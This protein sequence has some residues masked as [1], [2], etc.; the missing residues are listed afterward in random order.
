MTAKLTRIP[1][2]GVEIMEA[3]Q[4]LAG[5]GVLVGA[6]DRPYQDPDGNDPGMMVSEILEI[7]E[8]GLG[9]PQ[10]SVIRATLASRKGE[11]AA[12]A[13]EAA[14]AVTD[15]ADPGAE[16]EGVG[17]WLA[18]AFVER[19][20]EGISPA[21]SEETLADPYPRLS[22]HPLSKTGQILDYLTSIRLTRE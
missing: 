12:F 19:V 20:R 21:L 18:D 5:L 4:K 14:K 2:P 13:R 8:Y 3:V 16:V 22:H 15:G 17:L 10:R 1:G 6:D 9:V 7:H 11:L